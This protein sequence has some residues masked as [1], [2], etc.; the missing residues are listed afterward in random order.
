[1]A[2]ECYSGHMADDARPLVRSALEGGAPPRGQPPQP[3]KFTREQFDHMRE[4]GFFA[5]YEKVELFEGVVYLYSAVAEPTPPRFTRAQFD[6]MVTAG[7]FSE[8]E[9]VELFE[10]E[11]IS[12]MGEGNAHADAV[13]LLAKALRG[14]AAESIDVFERTRLDLPD[15]TEVYPDV[16]VCLAGT[17]TKNLNP[18]TVKL[19]IETSDSSLSFDRKRKG[20]RYAASGFQE[21]WIFDVRSRRLWICRD[22][23]A[24]GE[25][26]LVA[27][28]EGDAM[29]SP[30]FAPDAKIMLPKVDLDE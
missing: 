12:M 13:N 17:R 3:R 8:G 24:D 27:K 11:V 1:M 22:P 6:E 14:V 4:R 2:P 26:G 19:V 9:R 18:Q 15:G 25:W 10:G 28:V 23:S 30:L 16:L 20:P 29:A 7:F 21:Y 5:E